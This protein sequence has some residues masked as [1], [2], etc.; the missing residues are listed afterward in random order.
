MLV[1]VLDNNFHI[2]QEVSQRSV[3][4]SL[5]LKVSEVIILMVNDALS[6][7][8]VILF[9]LCKAKTS[10]SFKEI[11]TLV[12]NKDLFL[13]IEVKNSIKLLNCYLE[14]APFVVSSGLFVDNLQAPLEDIVGV[15]LEVLELDFA[16]TKLVKYAS[17]VK[18]FTEFFR[19]DLVGDFSLSLGGNS[20]AFFNGLDVFFNV[21]DSVL[22]DRNSLIILVLFGG[23]SLH[24]FSD[25]L[26][27]VKY[28]W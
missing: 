21:S 14:V 25:L 13:I 20:L 6:E 17:Y 5:R 11:R 26:Y 12:L 16:C 19:L 1:A 3:L 15:V 24:F 27:N 9:E 18:S 22:H 28:N 4:L 23:V 8:K 2:G 7:D 10:H